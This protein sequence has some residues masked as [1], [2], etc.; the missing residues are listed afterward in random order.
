MAPPATT[1]S[2]II[3]ALGPP[4]GENFRRSE[5]DRPVHN[6]GLTR[7][8]QTNLSPPFDVAELS[9]KM[10]SPPKVAGEPEIWIAPAEPP[11]IFIATNQAAKARLPVKHAYALMSSL[12]R[13]TKGFDHASVFPT[14]ECGVP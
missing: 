7:G 5:A 11:A 8:F 9:L 4:V 2:L 6:I 12:E 1:N 13:G 14:S 3:N 10:V